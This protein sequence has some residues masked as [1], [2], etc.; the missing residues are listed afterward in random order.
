MMRIKLTL[1]TTINHSIN[2]YNR[3]NLTGNPAN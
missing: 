3:D 1:A 2:A